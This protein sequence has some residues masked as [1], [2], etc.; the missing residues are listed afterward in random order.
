M[1]NKPVVI[2]GAGP[3]G[4][5][6]AHELVNENIRPIVLEK[7]DK[8]GGISR[9]ENYNGYLLDIGGHRFLTRFETIDRLWKD[10]LKEDFLK[11]P[12]LS[13]ILSGSFFTLS[14]QITKCPFQFRLH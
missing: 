7:A 9:T 10:M 12:R 1:S 3:A 8:V 6:A 2:I 14:S 11:V 5:A 13:R 4:L